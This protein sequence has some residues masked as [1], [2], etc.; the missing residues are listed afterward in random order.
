MNIL[1]SPIAGVA[2]CEFTVF[3]DLRG[4]FTR[5]FCERELAPVLDGRRILQINH[6]LTRAQGAIRGL[7]Y[8]RAPHA[9]MKFIRCIRGKVWDVAVDIRSG[10]PT[11]LHWHAIELS[12]E[13]GR[14]LVIPEGCAHGFQVL[15][16]DSEMLYFHTAMY[17]RASEGSIAYHDPSLAI[18]WPLAPTDLSERDRHYPVLSPQFQGIVL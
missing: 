4:D 15:E 17:D 9:E 3:S 12:P 11:F 7:H 1:S 2:V 18:D 8:Q 16:P 14:T 13:S 6:S 5:L 10:S